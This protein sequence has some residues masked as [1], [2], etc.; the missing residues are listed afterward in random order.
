MSFDSVT[1]NSKHPWGAAISGT[2]VNG[3][4]Y[5]IKNVSFSN[6]HVTDMGGVT[7]R[8]RG[9]NRV[10]FFGAGVL[11]LHPVSPLRSPS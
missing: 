7:S 5:R 2:N 11:D 3:T 10:A 6:I 8:S 1:G 9:G 4:V